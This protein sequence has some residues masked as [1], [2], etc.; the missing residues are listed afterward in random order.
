VKQILAQCK[1]IAIE[2]HDYQCEGICRALDGDD[3]VATM[4]TGA[5][6]TGL[7]SFLMLVVRAISQDPSLALQN[8]TFPKDPCML[9]I[10]P[11]KALEEDMVCYV[12]LWL[13]IVK[14]DHG[15]FNRA[16]TCRDLD[17]VQ[18]LSIQTQRL[19]RDLPN[20]TCG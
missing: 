10:C 11:T 4:A 12:L 3:V 8:R 15:K 6:K 5:G 1:P 19:K 16:Q 17:C 2:P 20:K 9:V 13:Q 7:L 18:W 14:F